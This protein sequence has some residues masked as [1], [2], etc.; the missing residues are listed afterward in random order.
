M[1]FVTFG[2][3]SSIV[4]FDIATVHTCSVLL[5]IRALILYILP[6]AKELRLTLEFSR[7]LPLLPFLIITKRLLD[8][9]TAPPLAL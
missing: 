9:S 7:I 5:S 2:A 4:T 3:V 6:S 1:K 8:I